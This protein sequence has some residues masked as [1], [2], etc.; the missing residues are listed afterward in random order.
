MKRNRIH[1]ILCLLLA[2]L[3]I[4]ALSACSGAG[5]ETE[6]PAPGRTEPETEAQTELQPG[7]PMEPEQMMTILDQA[8]NRLGG[9]DGRAVCTAADAG[10]LYSV[11]APAEYQYTATA[12]YRFFRTED[13]KDLLLGYLE[14]QSY[15]AVYT[16]TELEGIVYTLAVTGN[17]ADETPDPL[18]LLALDPA[19][20]TMT[21]YK[22]SKD[23]FPYAS[24]AAVGGKLLILNHETLTDRC[25]K[26]L[27][28]D[29]GSGAVR[30]LLSFP[31]DGVTSL[32]GVC[33]AEDGFYLLRLR[34]EGGSPAELL[35]DRY[36]R[37]GGKR[38]EKSLNEILV[39]AA[40]A[41]SGLV[42][43]ADVRNEFGMPVSGFSVWE[44]RY[45]Y[46]EN[47]GMLR[48]VL[49]LERGAA[50]LTKDDLWSLSGGSGSPGVYRLDFDGEGAGPEILE[51]QDGAFTDLSIEPKDGHRMLRALSHAPGGV[52][53]LRLSDS[54]KAY[55]A[56][57]VLYLWQES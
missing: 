41:V 25:D 30:E 6:A 43:E 52:W 51:L 21:Q 8:G 18:W 22:V 40:K 1:T 47:F 42:S 44:D 55:A 53:L 16:R 36:D 4:A 48:A 29:P 45:L 9:I 24:M 46:Y 26:L 5:T 35:L 23:G 19:A 10:V 7:Q 32:R 3:M 31:D 15:E 17:P 37:E 28:F 12:E 34:L 20:E 13:R 54:D 33:A 49:D 14:D 38:S 50:L 56:S 39:P 57:E 11:F 27:E 2:V